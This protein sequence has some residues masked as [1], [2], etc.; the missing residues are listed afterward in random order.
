[1][2]AWTRHLGRLGA[3]L[4][5]SVLGRL[6]QRYLDDGLPNWAAAVAYHT[7]VSVFPML[8]ALSTLLGLVLH[9]PQRLTS[10]AGA[11]VRIFPPEAAEPLLAMLQGTRENVGLLG[12]IS[13]AGLIYGGSALFGSLEEVF[14]RIY[15][16]PNRGFLQQKIMATGML[17][18]FAVLLLLAL[19]TTSLAEL[20]GSVS[21]Q[22]AA[23]WESWIPWLPALF[24]IGAVA[25][26]LASGLSLGWAFLLFLL[27]YWVVP[28][29]SFTLA[30]LWPGA[31]LAAVLFV[32]ITELF[33]LYLVYFGHFNRY[34]TA[35]T[36][37]LLLLAWFYFLA[38]IILLGATLNAFIE[39]TPREPRRS[40]SRANGFEPPPDAAAPEPVREPSSPPTP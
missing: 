31:A 4:R 6:L 25:V 12:L 13:V 39:G 17:L 37:V 34:G 19:V 10:V 38:H 18:L 24:D 8:L 40:E 33:P 21:R 16:V 1:M 27:I 15:R 2:P 29:R 28:N 35:F 7:L 14:D 11:I 26:R 5:H 30:Q 9:D 20:L 32:A 3:R 23:D 36:L 22:A